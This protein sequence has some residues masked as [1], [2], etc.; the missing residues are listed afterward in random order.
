MLPKVVVVPEVKVTPK[1]GEVLGDKLRKNKKSLKLLQEQAFT[2]KQEQEEQQN[3]SHD[4][5]ATQLVK[6]WKQTTPLICRASKAA[7]S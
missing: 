2:S 5:A 1:V 6:T 3:Q 7:D 4:L